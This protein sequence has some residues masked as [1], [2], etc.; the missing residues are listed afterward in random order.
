MQ[1]YNYLLRSV[2]QL[3]SLYPKEEALQIMYWVYEDVLLLKN[4]HLQYLD[5]E[6]GL[7]EESKLQEILHRLLSGEPLQYV[8][9]YAYFRNK[10]YK[11][12]KDV[13]IPRPETEELVEWICN[14]LK[15]KFDGKTQLRILDI[16]TGSGCIALAIKDELRNA[17]VSGI[18]ISQDAIQMAILNADQLKLTINFKQTSVL[19]DSGKQWIL[20]SN[21][22]VMVSNPPYIVEGDKKDMH[23][24]VINFEPHIALFVPDE[25]PL[26]FYRNI[27]HLFK[28]HTTAR[29]L[30]F[31]I[32]EFQEVALTAL[33]KF[34]ALSGI[35]KKDLQGKTRMLQI[36][37]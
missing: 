27:I 18:D 35:F 1:A 37:K 34:N 4:T 2:Q 24:N 5:K 7:A 11:V 33:C 30:F 19:E 3:E 28:E 13:L 26:L 16:G 8:L 22:D 17:E 20:S 12:T 6:I 23:I 21:L 10:V 15:L 14:E 31:E 9:G 36:S 25:D 29:Y 32:S